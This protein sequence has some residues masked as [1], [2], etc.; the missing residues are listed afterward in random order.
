[1]SDTFHN[2]ILRL[3]G[4]HT[5]SCYIAAIGKLWD[6]GGLKYVLVDYSVFAAGIVDQMLNGKGFNR[7]VRS[8]KLAYETLSVS[9]LDAFFSWCVENNLMKSF[10]ER[11]WSC[12]SE[13]ASNF[14]SV[15]ELKTS[16]DVSMY[17]IER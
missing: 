10:P 8:L 1:M 13:V 15:T 3:G 11:F 5:L 12:L 9:W 17:A 16:I 4:F 2:H 6:D 7:A 14:Q